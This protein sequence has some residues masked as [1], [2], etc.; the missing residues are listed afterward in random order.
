ML[1]KANSLPKTNTKKKTTKKPTK[2]PIQGSDEWFK[3]TINT[4]HSEANKKEYSLIATVDLKD[5]E[6]VASAISG[7]PLIIRGMLESV[8]DKL[9]LSD[10]GNP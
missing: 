3:D 7:N 2:K 4:L 9:I 6:E 1:K 5:T 8:R 10:R